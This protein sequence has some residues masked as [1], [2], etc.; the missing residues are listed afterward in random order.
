MRR[1]SPRLRA[2][3]ALTSGWIT[4]SL[5]N[6][7]SMHASVGRICS[8][9]RANPLLPNDINVEHDRSFLVSYNYTITPKMVNEF[10]FGFTQQSD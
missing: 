4:T 8:R 7:R 6:S 10:R 5:R 9:I 3:M 1:C 2:P